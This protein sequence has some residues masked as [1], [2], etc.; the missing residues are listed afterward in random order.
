MKFEGFLSQYL[1]MLLCVGLNLALM[2]T[3]F[4]VL[5]FIDFSGSS[6][7]VGVSCCFFKFCL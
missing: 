5:C 6:L 3:L 7:L 1:F 4:L 2:L